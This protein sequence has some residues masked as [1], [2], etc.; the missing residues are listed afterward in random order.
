M[1]VDTSKLRVGDKIWLQSKLLCRQDDDRALEEVW[2]LA[3]VLSIER[4]TLTVQADRPIGGKHVIQKTS[5]EKICYS[6]PDDLVV[7]DLTS[8]HHIHEPAILHNLSQHFRNPDPYSYM[9]SI[10]I[11]VNPL[12]QVYSKEMSAY[13]GKQ[14]GD[15]PPHPYA[16]AESAYQMMALPLT[17]CNQSVVITGE[18]GSGKTETS[19]IVLRFLAS[20]ATSKQESMSNL[21]ERLIE[22]NPILE[23]FGNAKTLRNHN[24]SRFG[25]FMKLLF[26]RDQNH[27]CSLGGAMIETYLLEKSRVISQVKKERNFHVFYQLFHSGSK[28]DWGLSAPQEVTYLKQSQCYED[29]H[30]DDRGWFAELQH[31]MQCEGINAEQV[32]KTVAAVLMLGNIVFD[33]RHEVGKAEGAA[34]SKSSASALSIASQM[35]GVQPGLLEK[36]LC[37][38]QM[39]VGG[40]T[41]AALQTKDGASLTRDA[42]AKAIYAQLFD[43][44][45]QQL[46]GRLNQN[47]VTLDDPGNMYIGV[48]DIFGFECYKRN[49]FEQL[50]INFTNEELHAMYTQKVV[51]A[52]KRLYESEGL[53][54]VNID[55]TFLEEQ[56][57]VALVSYSRWV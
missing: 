39:S 41:L 22:T 44:I 15:E 53:R 16:V 23:A 17:G 38:R 9:A 28:A 10:L 51:V 52:E 33:E 7:T 25:K 47:G 31:A 18:S 6:N 5:L 36:V 12:Q 32:L 56:V 40:D 49:G 24:S 4:A 13:I 46:N 8:L 45:V 14:L 3:S 29:S 21:D 20:R 27:Q 19:K 2:N 37:E 35:L 34:V 26:V 48:L 54:A 11:A 1:M 42:I 30:I 43:Y 55:V 50:L 57:G